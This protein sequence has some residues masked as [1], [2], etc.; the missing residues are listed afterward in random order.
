MGI[1]PNPQPT[2]LLPILTDRLGR[3]GI[4]SAQLLLVLIL[5]SAVI[6]GLIQLK[7]VVIPVLLAVILGAAFA[8]LVG[9]LRAHGVPR[10]LAAWVTLLGTLFLLTLLLV[11]VVF[12]VENQ[13]TS[14][15]ESA[16]DGVGQL[17]R[18]LTDLN[19]PID[20]KRL[21][22]FRQQVVEYV[23]SAEFG[24][25]ALGGISLVTE[26]LT[27]MF[28]L[29]V[30]LFFFLKDGD[31]IWRFLLGPLSP[32]R[33]SRGERIGRT[34]VRVL[35]G[36]VRGTAIVALVDAIAIGAAL[37]ILQVPLA[38]PLTVVVFVTAFI[39]IV[40]A[41]LA[42]VLAALVALVANGPVVA[43]IVVAVVVAVNQLE[44]DLLQPL[45]MGQSLKLHPL[46]ILLALTAGTIL[47]GVIGAILSVPIAAVSWAIVKVWDNPEQEPH[48]EAIGPES[49]GA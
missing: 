43:L 5:T 45:V 1:R 44:G 40:G 23:T 15:V 39:P 29:I 24:S 22:D 37:F 3:L 46:V 12:A 19:I 16:S 21:E 9:W 48:T 34:G 32:E 18:L 17:Q 14:L 27:G 31:T 10:T 30:V 8:P 41:T 49:P 26:L 2:R 38:L 13:W 7:V 36:Y 6:W 20:E 4:R 28:L 42:G 47:G 33:Q 25:R 11:L 35:G